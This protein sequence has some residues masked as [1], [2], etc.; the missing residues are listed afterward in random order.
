MREL[1]PSTL[2][3]SNAFRLNQEAHIMPKNVPVETCL[4]LATGGH[5]TGCNRILPRGQFT[6]N[7]IQW[8]SQD[9]ITE[10]PDFYPRNIQRLPT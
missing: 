8:Y 1:R 4:L 6:K 2:S 9:F 7:S 3:Q 5:V 10:S